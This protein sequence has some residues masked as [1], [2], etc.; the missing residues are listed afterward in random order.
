MTT[1]EQEILRLATELLRN[2]PNVGVSIE[3][4]I[5]AMDVAKAALQ[6]EQSRQVTVALMTKALK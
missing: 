1:H 2:D 6:A 4:R 3:Y 5:A